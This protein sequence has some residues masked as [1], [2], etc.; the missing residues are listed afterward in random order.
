MPSNP[1]RVPVEERLF[2]LVLALLASDIGLTKAEILSAVQG[3]RQRYLDGGDNTSLERLFE[4]D[5]DDLRDLGVPLETVDSPGEPGNNQTSRYRIP[6]G[7]YELPDDVSFTPEETALLALAAQVWKEGSL[8]AE[9]RRALFKLGSLGVEASDPVLG[10]APRVRLADPAFA[11]LQDAIDRGM[12]VRFEYLKPGETAATGRQVI[13][14]ALVQYEGRWH[15]AADDVATGE[16]RTFLLR[17]IVGTV[18]AAGTASARPGDH[19]SAALAELEEL[20]AKQRA[21][22]AVVPGSDAALRLARRGGST[23]PAPDRIVL[24][25]VDRAILADELAGFGPEVRVIEPADLRAAV[26]DRLERTAALHG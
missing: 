6:R 7:A 26:L 14:L 19:Q 2:S 16:P 10:Y 23:L 17:R 9:S 20:A 11:P 3:Y 24:G 15:L 21:V 1:A 4:R 22:L 25:Y 13:P 12:L 18:S 8:S 5:K